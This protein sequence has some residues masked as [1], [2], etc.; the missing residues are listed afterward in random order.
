MQ[1]P[2]K[3]LSPTDLS[4][5]SRT[6][7]RFALSLATRDRVE[8]LV[9]HVARDFPLRSIPDEP[10]VMDPRCVRWELLS[11]DEGTPR[12]PSW[13]SFFLCGLCV[14]AGDTPCFGCGVATWVLLGC[15][16]LDRFVAH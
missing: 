2:R 16:C 13:E 6:G 15:S 7:L 4:E 1:K 5:N 14:F 3:I 12:T 11:K 9:L 10:G 8:L